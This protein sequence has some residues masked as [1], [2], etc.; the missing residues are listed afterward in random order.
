MLKI[1]NSYFLKVVS[2]RYKKK[3]FTVSV[4]YCIIKVSLNE[5]DHFT[6]S[7]VEI[8]SYLILSGD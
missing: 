5:N 2:S 7:T 1:P 6:Y 4:G 3:L 8:R